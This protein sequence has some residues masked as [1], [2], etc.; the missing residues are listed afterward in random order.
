N[1]PLTTLAERTARAAQNK[2]SR[3]DWAEARLTGRFARRVPGDVRREIAQAGADADLYIAE[4]N[5]WMH[6]V[7]DEKGARP[8]PR[9]MR[10]IAHWNLRDELKADYADAK[11]GATKQRLI[12]QVMERIVTQTIPRAVID[13]PRLDWEPFS[14]QVT[15]APPSE[16]E[17]REAASGGKA[18]PPAVAQAERE[19]D[20]RYAKLLAQFHAMR[21]VDPFSPRE[22]TAIAR[23]FEAP[24][25]LGRELPEQRVVALLEELLRSPLV[26]R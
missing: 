26:A 1:F 20:V 24:A 14:N 19:Q 3:R 5:L 8:F 15:P 25:P 12:L 7:L 9:G 6:H 2:M 10:L 23:A 13:D 22:P 11:D 17:P 18:R 4:Y 21:R 16:I